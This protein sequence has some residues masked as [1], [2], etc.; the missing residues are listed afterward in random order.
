M[1]LELGLLYLDQGESYLALESMRRATF[2]D[3]RDPFAQFMLGRAGL[4][5]GERSLAERAFVYALRLLSDEPDES[6]IPETDLMVGDLRHAI[7]TELSALSAM[8]VRGPA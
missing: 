2:L 5:A 4:R 3:P 6:P 1:H 8:V 7:E